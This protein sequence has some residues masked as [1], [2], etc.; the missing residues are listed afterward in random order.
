MTGGFMTSAGRLSL[1][2][3]ASLLL[4]GGTSAGAADFGG[5][6]C[7]DLE[8]RIAELEATTARK[9]NRKVKLEISGQV[10]EAVL[11]WDDGVESNVGVYT[12]DAA[13]T[14][15]RFRG[16]AKINDEWKA[17][18]LLEVGVRS[19]NSKRFDQD[20]PS[21]I[22]SNGVLPNGFDLRH[23]TWYI[24]SKRLGRVWV[25]LTGG[26]AEGITEI[27]VA[28]TG[29]VAKFSDTEDMGGD[30]ILLRPDGSRSGNSIR[31]L[32]RNGSGNQPGEGRRYNLV[33]YDTPELFGFTGTASWGADDTWEI[34]LRYKGE[35]SGFKLAAGIAYGESTD[36]GGTIGF[37]CTVTTDAKCSQLGGSISVMHVASGLY[38][39][40]AAGYTEDDNIQFVHQ[41]LGAADDR[42]EFWAIEAG[43]QQKWIP[44]G[45]TTVFGQYY[46][47]DGGASLR[48]LSDDGVNPALHISSSN[49]DIYSIGLMQEIDAAAMKLYAIY[50]HVDADAT[51]SAGAR[52]DFKDIDMFMTGAV[53]RF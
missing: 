2:G 49:L 3:A 41:D 38:V 21:G 18:Y 30:L 27:N 19:A 29:D 13:R 23:S 36:E 17:G 11:F 35:F 10:N 9:G 8:E 46:S 4:L 44:L 28:G 37:E 20:N 5:N 34:G 52:V 51:N 53:I 15:F 47:H 6:C 25:G 24:D 32:I 42:H 43:I 33:R 45:K 39:N 48:A 40:A 14:R 16:D 50:R 1:L 22:P 12:N 7:A 26:A 31:R